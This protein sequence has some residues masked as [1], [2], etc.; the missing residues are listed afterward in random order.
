MGFITAPL[1]LFSQFFIGR[2]TEHLIGVGV[3][4]EHLNDSR[5]GRVLDQL[6]EYG[7]SIGKVRF[8]H[9]TYPDLKP[10]KNLNLT[11]YC[12]LLILL[13]TFQCQDVQCSG[14]FF[15]T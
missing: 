6:Y 13:L 4:A 12:T 5:L 2:A 15:V 8:C 9:G 3:E 10:L 7:V 11:I 1:Y 14:Y